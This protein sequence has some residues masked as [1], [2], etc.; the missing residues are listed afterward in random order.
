MPKKDDKNS[1]KESD[2]ENRDGSG[3]E[4][5]EEEYVVEKVCDKRIEKGKVKMDDKI[6]KSGLFY[7]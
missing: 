3:S 5:E 6:C 4:A 7:D 2:S 1:D